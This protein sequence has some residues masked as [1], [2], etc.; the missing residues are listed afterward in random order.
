MKILVTAGSTQSPIDQ[1][2]VITNIF[3]GRT[4]TE[5]AKKLDAKHE[6]TLITSNPRMAESPG[7]YGSN[8]KYRVLSF[9]TFDQLADLME[10]EI[11]TGQY[12]VIIH[13]AAVSDYRVEGVFTQEDGQLQVVVADSKIPSSH[14]ELFLRLTPTFK[15]VDK[16]RSEWGFEGTLIKFKLQVNMT[17][18]DLIKR[19]MNSRLASE[20]DYIVANCLEWSKE[21]A[22]IIDSHDVV[23][24]VSRLNLPKAVERVIS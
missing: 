2:R 8:Y 12:D 13:S 7:G 15:I 21:Y 3:R 11:C 16:I 22:L 4:G 14:S 19:A 10:Q 6:V 23:E 20:A 17:E 9:K 18:T 5:I 1:V 24:R